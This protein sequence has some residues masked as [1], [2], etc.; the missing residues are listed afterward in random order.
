MLKK[1]LLLRIS[2]TIVELRKTGDA[3]GEVKKELT[4][5]DLAR[6][7]EMSSKTISDYEMGKINIKMLVLE[8]I[9]KL[10]GYGLFLGIL[11][12]E[13]IEG[14]IDKYRQCVELNKILMD[15]PEDVVRHVLQDLGVDINI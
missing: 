11:P 7:L 6:D 1:P 10:F 8:K 4:Q 14:D 3:E 13:P 12:E 2:D 9:V 15:C 5:K